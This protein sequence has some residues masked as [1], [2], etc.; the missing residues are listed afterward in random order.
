MRRR[1][2][3]LILISALL[4][5]AVAL[6][7]PSLASA[8]P[9]PYPSEPNKESPTLKV[10]SPQNGK[11]YAGDTVELVFTVTKPDSWN[12]YWL[13]VT[14]GLP[15]IGDYS[16]WVYLDG[17]L[18]ETCWDPCLRDVPTTNYPVV[19]DGLMIGGHSLKIDV[20]ARTFYENP[21]PDPQD[22][23]EYLMNVSETIHFTIN[24][25]L[26]SSQHPSQ[27]TTSTPERA[28]EPFPTIFVAAS[29]AIV[30]TAS[31]LSAAYYL[32][33]RK[34]KKHSTPP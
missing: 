32:R 13:G 14:S 18:K 31:G 23:L 5:V 34:N 17:N 21:N 6:H 15:I 2:L 29:A 27:E 30:A 7:F 25:G 11:V 20:R 8:N 12:Y 22:Y 9:V 24:S 3:A 28:P 33:K 26:P 1:T 10:E 4:L 19:L 16:V